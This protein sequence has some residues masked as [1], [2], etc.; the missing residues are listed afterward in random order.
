MIA[1]K[2][3]FTEITEGKFIGEMIYSQGSKL[4]INDD[5]YLFIKNKFI[6]EETINI[7][8]CIL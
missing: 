3:Y 8:I 1:Y 6:N 5:A 2:D 4:G 7:G